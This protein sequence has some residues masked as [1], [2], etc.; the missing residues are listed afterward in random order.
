MDSFAAY[1]SSWAFVAAHTDTSEL[2][3]QTPGPFTS[4]MSAVLASCAPPVYTPGCLG[5]QVRVRVV[6][7]WMVISAA[8]CASARS[9]LGTTRTGTCRDL[10]YNVTQPIYLQRGEQSELGC[11]S[12]VPTSPDCS[13]SL[14]LLQL[15][16]SLFLYSRQHITQQPVPSRLLFS[17][18]LKTLMK[19]LPDLLW[20]K[21]QFGGCV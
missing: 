21:C 14:L 8:A 10:L 13:A 16:V 17:L 20:G 15:L 3:L 6:L 9:L 12:P 2:T 1:L 7:Q 19:N 5:A 4:Y 18:F 11:P